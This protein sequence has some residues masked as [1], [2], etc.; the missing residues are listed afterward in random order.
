MLLVLVPLLLLFWPTVFELTHSF[1]LDSHIKRPTL[2]AV[3][4]GCLLFVIFIGSFFLPDI[5][6]STETSTFQ[7]HFLGG[8]VLSFVLY[9]HVKKTLK[10]SCAWWQDVALM[11]IFVSTL[12]VSNE[13]LEFFITKSGLG[14]IDSSDVWWDLAA[15]TAGALSAITLYLGTKHLIVFLR[16][17]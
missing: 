5:H 8:G 7:Q 16:K 4:V 15:N 3:L 2:S 1:L 11:Y 9:L 13:L 6:I 14:Y 10:L 17:K 12:G